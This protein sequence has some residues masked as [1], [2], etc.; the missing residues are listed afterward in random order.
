MV[1]LAYSKEE[2]AERERKCCD[3]P[4]EYKGPKYPWG[5][6]ITLETDSL[7]KLGKTVTDFEVGARIP[8]TI[9][10]EVSNISMSQNSDGSK[11]QCVGLLCADM[12]F[13]S[14]KRSDKEMAETLY[15]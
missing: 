4:M 3:M 9:I 2:L 15:K 11:H 12:E 6:N 8:I 7:E 13:P 5:L 10:A 1:D 14:A